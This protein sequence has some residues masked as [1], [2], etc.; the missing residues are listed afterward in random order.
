MPPQDNHS[1]ASNDPQSPSNDAQLPDD[2]VVVWFDID[3]TLYS[4]SAKISQAMGTLI[5]GQTLRGIALPQ[6]LTNSTTSSLFRQPGTR[7]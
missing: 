6:F 4:A 5:H 3:N 1:T 2:R 7:P